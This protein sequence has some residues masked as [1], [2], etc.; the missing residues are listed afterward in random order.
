MNRKFQVHL[1]QS[2]A[3]LCLMILVGG[4]HVDFVATAIK[5]NPLLNSLI[6]II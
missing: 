3:P 4:T 1:F 5:G 2:M 6:L